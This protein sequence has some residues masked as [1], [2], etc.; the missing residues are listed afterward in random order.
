[1]NSQPANFASPA[2][3]VVDIDDHALQHDIVLRHFELARQ[4]GNKPADDRF[5]FH[6]DHRIER[7]AHAHVGDVS[8]ARRQNPLVRR[9]HVG[10]G[11]ENN[12]RPA[13]EIPTHGIF[14]R[15]RFGV[16]VDDH[17][18]RLRR[19]VALRISSTQR[20]GSST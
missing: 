5:L 16:H 4:L 8:G 14:F 6:A 18:W 12:R 20:N 1:M 15:S 9:L 11:A 3:L 17:D 2:V 13:V 10:V 7:A 19:R